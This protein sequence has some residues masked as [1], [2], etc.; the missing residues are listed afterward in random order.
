LGVKHIVGVADMRISNQPGDEII[1]YALGSCIGITLWDPIANVGGM[2]HV[3]LPSSE[4]DPAKAPNNPAMFV[5]TG[6][7]R[8]F[9]ESYRLGASKGRIEV[10]AAGGACT[11]GSD[12]DDYFQIGRRNIRIL[13]K[14]LW[15]NRV[16]LKATDF[17]GTAARTMSLELGTG[18]VTIRSN[19]ISTVLNRDNGGG[20]T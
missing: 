14:L 1:T 13:E 8:L 5:D 6:V 12:E 17:A 7:A 3:M 16:V 4:I 11:G 15:T 10:T 19:G 2:V 9:I 20:A 18:L